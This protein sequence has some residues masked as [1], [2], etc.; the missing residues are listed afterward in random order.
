MCI[1]ECRCECLC[2]H[3]GGGG[4]TNVLLDVSPVCVCE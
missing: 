2:V 3:V 1:Y 4:L